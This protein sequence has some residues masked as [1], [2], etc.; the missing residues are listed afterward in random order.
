MI[1]DSCMK[2]VFPLQSLATEYT[3]DDDDDQWSII[4]IL[5]RVLSFGCHTSH[6]TS[7]CSSV[8]IHNLSTP[9]CLHPQLWNGVCSTVYIH[10]Q[11]LFY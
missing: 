11:Y 3:G 4:L 1:L 5:I 9:E 10:V 2:I 6:F 8:L 7:M